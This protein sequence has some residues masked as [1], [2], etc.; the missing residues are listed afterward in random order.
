VVQ[1]RASAIGAR[2]DRCGVEW[3]CW[4]KDGRMLVQ[5]EDRLLDLPLPSLM[6]PHQVDNA[7]L[8]VR[9]AVLMQPALSDDEIGKG[10]AS[11]QW[12]ARMQF[13]TQGPLAAQV[14]AGGGE[15]W[16]DGGHN[17][18]AGLALAATLAQLRTRAP[19]PVIAIC[20]MLGTKDGAGFF[21]AVADQIDGVVTAPIPSS[22]A[23]LDPQ[24]LAAI[25]NA[26]GLRAVAAHSLTEAISFALM[27]AKAS[28]II[29]CGS[30]YLAG[31]A[32]MLSG[33]ELE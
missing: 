27:Q 14:R 31:E 18:H 28:R 30:L 16:I 9:A 26:Q 13:I 1:A 33:I 2:L 7:G 22:R 32:L 21:G 25:A 5:T 17:V 19:K 23:A 8:A 29:I 3:D 4:A 11:A 12:P 20:G 6:G 10:V 24:D 15:L